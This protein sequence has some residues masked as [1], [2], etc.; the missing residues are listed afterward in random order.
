MVFAWYYPDQWERLRSLSEDSE[1]LEKRYEDW[2]RKALEKFDEAKR[3]GVEP[4]KVYVDL[5]MLL[6]WCA[7]HSLNINGKTRSNYAS[8]LFSERMGCNEKL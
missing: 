1:S 8:L 5:D 6:S 4:H 2:Q 7:S 3:D